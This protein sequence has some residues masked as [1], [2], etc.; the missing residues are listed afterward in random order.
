M[1]AVKLFVGQI[2]FSYT[3]SDLTSL[4]QAYGTVMHCHV[5]AGKGAAFATMASLDDAKSAIAALHNQVTLPSG[6]GPV[7]VSL[8]HGEAARLGNEADGL[9]AAEH[10]K[11]FFG[12][13]PFSYGEEE[14]RA[15]LCGLPEG[16]VVKVHILKR[17]DG[18]PRGCAFVKIRGRKI[19]EQTIHGL[20]GK[21]QLPGAPNVLN[22][23]VATS[24]SSGSSGSSSAAASA[25][26]SGENHRKRRR[27]VEILTG[28]AT[29]GSG[30]SSSGGGSNSSFVQPTAQRPRLDTPVHKLHVANLS[31]NAESSDLERLFGQ[32]GQVKEVF[33]MRG[34]AFI[35]FGGKHEADAAIAGLNG[36]LQF[37]YS[38]PIRVS[39]AL[40]KRGRGNTA[41]HGRSEP[42]YGLHPMQQHMYGQQQFPPMM[43]SAF[44]QALPHGVMPQLPPQMYFGQQQPRPPAGHIPG[45]HW[46]TGLTLSVPPPNVA[47]HPYGSVYGRPL[48]PGRHR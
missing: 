32:F 13:L 15:L 10:V 7:Q 31:F 47:A 36:T 27:S 22:V 44:H 34:S 9:E 8:A 11:L 41:S 6:P 2:P 29:P 16:S 43:H 12:M 1:S 37:G 17:S 33:L 25:V 28:G 4:L 19:A 35:K 21:I 5:L 23:S 3:E 46:R 20:N 42:G 38:R 48:P 39:Y 14:M 24:G 30:A 26:S 45:P 40:E 18:Q